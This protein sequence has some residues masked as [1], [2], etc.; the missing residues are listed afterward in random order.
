LPIYYGN[1]N[2]QPFLVDTMR[3]MAADGVKR[4]LTFITGAYSSYSGCRQYRENIMDAQAQIGPSAPRMDKL[5]FYYN[6]PAFIEVNA[7]NVRTAL[8]QIP[9]ERRATA[10]IAFTA[11]SIPLS[12]AQHC[13][14]EAQLA[15]TMRLV[16]EMLDVENPYQLVYQS[17]SGSPHQPWLEPDILDHMD[18]LK[19]QGVADVVIMP[20]GFISDHMEVM[21]DLDTEAIEKGEEIAMNVVRAATVGVHPA[22]VRMIRDL[23]VERIEVEQGLNPERLALGSRGPLH[24]VCPVNCCLLG[25]AGRR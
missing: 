14:Y 19:T 16:V 13:Q 9:A 1:R 23:I 15:E 12:M 21:F 5:R 3:Q 4:A 24:D 10:T 22:F 6:H 25:P 2:W 8:A 18:A 11:H 7:E 20:I 17:R